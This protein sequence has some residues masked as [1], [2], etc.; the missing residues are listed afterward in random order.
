MSEE[1]TV[2]VENGYIMLT[3]QFLEAQACLYGLNYVHCAV[4]YN[5]LP[6]QRYCNFYS[7]RLMLETTQTPFAAIPVQATILLKS[8]DDGFS[9]FDA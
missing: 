6:P 3:D 9:K 4:G 8:V 5:I 2:Q 1:V 7:L